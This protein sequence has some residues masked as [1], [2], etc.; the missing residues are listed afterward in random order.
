M[1]QEPHTGDKKKEK[2]SSLKN[3]AHLSEKEIMALQQKNKR[4]SISWN[5][6]SNFKFQELKTSFAQ[7]QKR[8]CSNRDLPNIK[9]QKDTLFENKRRESIKDE[10]KLAKEFMSEPHV[11]LIEEED[12]IIK[13]NTLKNQKIKPDE[14]EKSDSSS[15][16]SNSDKEDN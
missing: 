14:E 13:V 8:N 4:N 7:D 11:E 15:S 16:H 2:R 1:S 9:T 5:L 6:S 12:Q 3:S 10:Y